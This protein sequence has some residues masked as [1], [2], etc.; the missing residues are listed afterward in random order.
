MSNST[1]QD[2]PSSPLLLGIDGGGTKTVA[3]LGCLRDGALIRIGEGKSGPSNPRAAGFEVAFQN[4][5]KATQLAFLDAQLPAAQL[6]VA[7]LCLAGTGRQQERDAV[8]NWARQVGLSKKSVIISEAEAVLAAVEIDRD[9]SQSAQRAEVALVCGTGSL[10]WGR[11]STQS[12]P[13]R[14]GGWGYLM[15]DEGSG[16]WLGQHVLQF[17]CKI[18][19]GREA[20][21]SL[22]DLVLTKLQ[23][24]A[25]ENL[26][27]WCYELP[28]SR[29]RIASLAPLAFMNSS[30]GKLKDIVNRGAHELALMI[31]AVA[32]RLGGLQY[33]LAMAGS[34]VAHQTEYRLLI[35]RYLN[36]LKCAP[37][38]IQ[39]VEQPVSGT[40][41]LALQHYG[42]KSHE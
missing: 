24:T 25:A 19:D 3:W 41:K 23:L 8:L 14:T 15:G 27:G 28:G 20:E 42:T 10:A 31:A 18:S 26:V 5:R 29:E 38:S 1:K 9:W 22:L 40:L 21:R 37:A 30:V 7:C 34:V 13:I 33:D 6:D 2:F 32:G 35:A 36:D 12:S 16:F 11:I 17:A 39:M 4:L